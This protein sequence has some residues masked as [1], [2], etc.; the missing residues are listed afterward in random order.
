M[1]QRIQLKHDL[2]FTQ[3]QLFPSPILTDKGLSVFHHLRVLLL[4]IP[5]ILF[6]LV[7][8]KSKLEPVRQPRI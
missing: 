7:L 3:E 4:S 5:R 8:L 6:L 2:N 1:H